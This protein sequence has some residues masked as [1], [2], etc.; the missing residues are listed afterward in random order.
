MDQAMSPKE[1]VQA[2]GSFSEIYDGFIAARSKLMDTEGWPHAEDAD[3]NFHLDLKTRT[4]FVKGDLVYHWRT[5]Y[6]WVQD[7]F[8]EPELL[9]YSVPVRVD[10]DFKLRVTEGWTIPEETRQQIWG[11]FLD[12]DRDRDPGTKVGFP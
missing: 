1:A 5:F 4:I 9:A 3:A 6:S 12:P 10:A 2:S 7:T 8:D 11:D